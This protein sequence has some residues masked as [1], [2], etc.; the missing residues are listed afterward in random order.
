MKVSFVLILIA[1]TSIINSIHAQS[2]DWLWAKGTGGT[3]YNSGTDVC[4]D[5]FGNVYMSGNFQS[6]TLTL[7]ATTLTNSGLSDIFIVKYDANGNELWA[8]KVGNTDQDIAHSI[9]ADA[10]GNIIITG[11]FFS[12]TLTFGNDTLLNSGLRDLLLQN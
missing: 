1:F 9:A 2:P 7:G 3:N 5:S 12:S 6:L 4:E 8:L 10:M 11:V